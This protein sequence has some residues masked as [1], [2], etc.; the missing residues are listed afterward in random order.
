MQRALRVFLKGFTQR[1]QR[2]SRKARKEFYLKFHAKSA[3]IYAKDAKGLKK[4]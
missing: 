3:K 4:V 2:I 1:A